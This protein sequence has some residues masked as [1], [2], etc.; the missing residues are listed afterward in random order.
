MYMYLLKEK[1]VIHPPPPT[2]RQ[3]PTLHPPS[4]MGSVGLWNAWVIDK[5]SQF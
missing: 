1:R 3:S 4:E 2:S 5:S